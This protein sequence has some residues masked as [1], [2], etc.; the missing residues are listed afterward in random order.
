MAFC[1]ELKSADTDVAADGLH[2]AQLKQK[3]ELVRS[4]LSDKKQKAQTLR[5]HVNGAVTH[6]KK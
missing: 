3:L 1:S 4:R 5:D 6:K 2:S